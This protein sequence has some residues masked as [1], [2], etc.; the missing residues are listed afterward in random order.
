M[1]LLDGIDIA[2]PN[3]VVSID[4]PFD[5]V[6]VLFTCGDFLL[7]SAKATRGIY[8]GLNAQVEIAGVICQTSFTIVSVQNSMVSMVFDAGQDALTTVAVLSQFLP[9]MESQSLWSA[10]INLS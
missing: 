1:S 2:E 9:G 6:R 3:L 8:V 4:N 10:L 7:I 5:K